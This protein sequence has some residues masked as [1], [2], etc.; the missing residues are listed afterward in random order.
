MSLRIIINGLIA[1]YPLGGVTWDYFQYVLGLHQLGHDVYYIEDTGQW[2]YT[3]SEDGL[4]K[5]CD[6]NVNYLAK[7]FD[8]YGMAI[9]GRTASPGRRPGTDCRTACARK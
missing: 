8:Q 3:P 2:P 9:V 5:E 4:V 6:F 1:Q 7:L